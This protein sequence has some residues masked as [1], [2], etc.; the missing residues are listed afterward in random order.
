MKRVLLQAGLALACV[1]AL[2]LIWYSL[3][4]AL[5]LKPFILPTPLAV[6]K[7]L[8][9]EYP[10]LFAHLGITLKT[11]LIGI[12]ISTAL[13]FVTAAI[14]ASYQKASDTFMPF[15]V[16]IKNTPVVALAP[17]VMLFFGRGI[18]TG[19]VVVMI[20]SFLPMLVNCLQGFKAARRT[21]L[22]L[23]HMYAAR[24]GQVFWKVRFP[25]ALPYVFAGLRTAVPAAVLGALL[26]EWLTGFRGIGHFI[27]ETASMRDM[28][29]LWAGIVVCMVA[30]LALFWF[31]ALVE[32]ISGRAM[33]V[34]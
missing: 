9:R 30:S 7:A 22:E 5:N 32:K 14:F 15:A 3:I 11:G 24:P 10:A 20:V 13:A 21:H 19:V 17:L 25:F 27:L 16:A 1:C 34:A 23:L 8:G 4:F 12:V 18:A 26:A 6:A 33:G 31:T 2:V 29:I 28:D